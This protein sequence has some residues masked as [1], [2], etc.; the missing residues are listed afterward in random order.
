MKT[1]PGLKPAAWGAV[2]DAVAI[3]VVGFCNSDGR[4]AAL[5]SES[6]PAGNPVGGMRRRIMLNPK[7]LRFWAAR[8]LR[9][10]DGTDNLDAI[11]ELHVMARDLERWATEAD[12]NYIL[13]ARKSRSG[14]LGFMPSELGG[15]SVET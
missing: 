6:R 9:S 5:L 11:T 2:F 1:Q 15:S 4:P 14:K 8:C 3:T 12:T 7:V 13:R 10:A